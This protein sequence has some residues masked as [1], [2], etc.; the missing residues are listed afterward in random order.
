MSQDDE[1][2]L[3][4][5]GSVLLRRRRTILALGLSGTLLGLAAGLLSTRVYM[6]AAIFIP[7]GSQEGASG[8]ALAASQF[9][10]RVP[11]SGGAWGPPVYVELLRSRALLEPIALD[12]VVVVEKGGRRV[13]LMDLLE[14]EAPTLARRTDLAVRA[15]GKI[16]T[17]SEDKKLGAVK[18][19]VTTE[20]PSVSL[21][22]AQ[23]LVRG[24]NKFNV[25]T[26]KSQATAERQFVEIQAGEAE[27][28]L[29]VSEDRLQVFL[30]GNRVIAGSPELTFKRDR[31]QRGVE[32][33]QQVYTTLL[34]NREEARI[35]EV[36]DTPVITVLEDPRLPVVGEARKSVQ[37]AVMGGLAGGML[38]VL[39]AFMVQ[40]VVAA[41]RAPSEE[42]REFFQLVEESTPRFLKT[43][44]S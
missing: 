23:R 5:I 22:L 10:I 32:L 8:L 6:S 35:R 12:S 2:S 7:Q 31:L 15:L 28:A 24:V 3:L 21:A 26:R 13:A 19:S 30:Q 37:K 38:G 42:A 25:E 1:I 18:L 29:R 36:R 27:R 44:R 16:V 33:R 39:I 14:V 40:G 34:Q 41:R 9:G 17:A 11:T 4:A 43:G 20:W